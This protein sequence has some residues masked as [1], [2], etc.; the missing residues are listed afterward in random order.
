MRFVLLC[1]LVLAN[2]TQLVESKLHKIPVTEK[3]LSPELSREI[4]QVENSKSLKCYT[5]FQVSDPQLGMA[6]EALKYWGVKFMEENGAELL[7]DPK[8]F[9]IENLNLVLSKILDFYETN[10][11]GKV[12]P[13]LVAITGD[14]INQYPYDVW[15]DT[16][17]ALLKQ[18]RHQEFNEIISVLSSPNYQKLNILTTPGNHD[19]GKYWADENYEEYF[20]YFGNNYYTFS[21][22]NWQEENRNL[23]SY[24]QFIF[25][26]SNLFLN[27]NSKYSKL[28]G[29]GFE[30]LALLR[31]SRSETSYR[32]PCIT[33]VTMS[34]SRCQE[35]ISGSDIRA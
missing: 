15:K 6:A 24:N 23:Q 16:T 29:K 19:V 21:D 10:S 27:G 14:M 30:N 34:K 1:C 13:K 31:R 25:L 11:Q 3:F 26:D 35:G 17:L 4:F 33:Q 9:E 12:S 8:K 22:Q 18:I 28:K 5:I 32:A 20:G 7:K 2:L